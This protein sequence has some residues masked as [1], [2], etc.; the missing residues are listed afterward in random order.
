[1]ARFLR[2]IHGLLGRVLMERCSRGVAR[3]HL[4]GY[5]LN[6]TIHP[7]QKIMNLMDFE[8]AASNSASRNVNGPNMQ[9]TES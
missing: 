3:K 1:M 2:V 5:I 8:N 7:T 4:D 6:W 9:F